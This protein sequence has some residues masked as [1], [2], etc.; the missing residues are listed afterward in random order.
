MILR[1][2]FE[3]ASS[4]YERVDKVHHDH[5]VDLDTG[6]IVEFQSDRIE[7]LQ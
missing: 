5:I 1:H 7:Q 2:S 3:G 4:R 6:E